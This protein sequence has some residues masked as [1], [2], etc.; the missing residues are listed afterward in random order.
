MDKSSTGDQVTTRVVRTIDNAFI[1]AVDRLLLQRSDTASAPGRWELEQMVAN[2][3]AI[4]LVAESAT[5]IVGFLALVVFRT[6]TGVRAR[7]EDLVVDE[8]A[9]LPHLTERLIQRATKTAASRGART[10]EATCATSKIDEARAYEQLGFER[11]STNAYQY[12]IS[13]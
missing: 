13:G 6:P 12:K 8:A 3:S 2:P 9:A 10:V 7:I 11:R 1:E 5:V 4:V